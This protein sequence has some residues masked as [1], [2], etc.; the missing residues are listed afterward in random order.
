M[1]D[2]FAHRYSPANI[3]LAF[4]GKTDWDQ[5]VALAKRTA[6]TG[7]A[8]EAD[9]PGRRRRRGPG[10]FQ[11]ILRADDQQQTVVGV[12]D[13]PPL[14]SDDRYAA[15][16]LATDPR[17]PH[18]LAALLGADRPRLRRRRRALVPGLQP[19]RRLLH[20]PELRAR[21]DPGQPRPDRRGLPRSAWPRASTDDEL[22]QAKNKVLARSVLRSERPM[23]RSGSCRDDLPLSPCRATG[24]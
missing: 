8:G 22:T 4:A 7:Q 12:A 18:R 6:A 14:E 20:L 11:A 21:R 19:G 2:Y 10:A 1:R 15:Q 3:V 9:A 24:R 17:R 13:A 16:L 23:G 5:V